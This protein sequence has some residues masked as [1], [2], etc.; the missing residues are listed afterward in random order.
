MSVIRTK[1]N[2]ENPFVQLNKHALRDDKISFKAKGLWAFCMSHHDDW[3]FNIS[4]L[5]KRSKEGRRAIDSG[6]AELIKHGYVVRLEY[7]DKSEQ[8]KFI[9]GGVEYVFFEFP[10][11]EEDKAQVLEEFKKR[12]RHCGFGNCRNGDCRNSKL[13]IKKETEKEKDKEENTSYFPAHEISFSSSS[14]QEVEAVEAEPIP[15][16]K[17]RRS[18]FSKEYSS[19][20]K[21]FAQ[22]MVNIIQSKSKT[23]RPPPDMSRFYEDVR[24]MLEDDRQDPK[25]LLEVFEWGVND[26]T[27]TERFNGWSSVLSSNGTSKKPTTPAKLLREHASRMERSMKA[28]PKE[29][30]D[31]RTVGIDG[32][33]M[34]KPYLQGLF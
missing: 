26:N 13:L 10:A 15:D 19:E 18:K 12:F 21:E 14:S 9:T 7:W 23:Y 25:F 34:E 16:K 30:V 24:V 17:P 22:K 27:K 4:E 3:S 6:I 20:V 2:R 28:A 31:R 1:H 11:T 32:K 29:K 8:G 5:A 33:P